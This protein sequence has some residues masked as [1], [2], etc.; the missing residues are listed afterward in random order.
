MLK[1]GVLINA[2]HNVTYAVNSTDI[3]HVLAAYDS[4]LAR[5]S[6]ELQKGDLDGRLGNDIIRPIFQVRGNG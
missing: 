1:E 5:L 6:E 4:A 2:S 3:D